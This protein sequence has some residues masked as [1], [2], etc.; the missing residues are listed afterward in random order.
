MGQL[1]QKVPLTSWLGTA[2]DLASW[3]KQVDRALR[4]QHIG[5]EDVADA[6]D[7]GRMFMMCRK[8]A[9]VVLQPQGERLLI[10]V[11]GGTQAGLESLELA[12]SLFGKSVGAKKLVA[13][14][15]EGFWRRIRR[16]GWKKARI[17]IEKEIA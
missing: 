10:V 12:A 7:D 4:G 5:F 2:H 8:E 11:G 3:R 15:R 9:F 16:Q 17:I 13:H 6:I 14:A 1:S